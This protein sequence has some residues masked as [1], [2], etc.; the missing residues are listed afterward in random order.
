MTAPHIPVMLNEVLEGLQPRDGGL[1]ID[2]TFG[3]GG[4]TRAILEAADCRVLGIDRDPS[5]RE[6]AERLKAAYPGRFAFGFGPFS[7]M[8]GILDEAD[9]SGA[10]GVVFDLGV[11]SMQIDQAERGFSFQKDGPLDMRMAQ[12]GP[13]AADAVNGLEAS[14]LAAIFRV[15]GEERQARRVAAAIVRERQVEPITTTLRL[16]DIIARAVGGKPGRIHPATRAFQGLR[17]CVNDELGEL[18]RGLVAAEYGLKPAGRMVVVT[19]HSLEDRLAKTF[20]R[21]RAGLV[22]GGSRYQPEVLPEHKPSFSLVS[23]K[24]EAATED[25]AAVNPRARS[26]KLRAAIRTSAEP[27]PRPDSAFPGAPSFDRLLEIAS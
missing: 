10:D 3:A 15:Y 1:Y 21:E 27:F 6:T 20:L 16:A 11:S 22:P 18:S 8:E 14:E 2:A 5:A 25:E 4:Y 12:S 7:M 13:S 19:F 17:I 9:S 26:A 23:K 24:A